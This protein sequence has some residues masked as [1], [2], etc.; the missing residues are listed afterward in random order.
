MIVHGKQLLH[1][2]HAPSFPLAIATKAQRKNLMMNRHLTLLLLFVFSIG[3]IQAQMARKIPM[4][5]HFTQASCGP[6]ATQN[7]IFEAVRTANIGNIN[8]VAVHTSWPGVDPMY[9]VNP[10]EA[11]AM[12]ALYGILGVPNMIMDGVNIGGPAGVTQATIDDAASDCSPVRVRVSETGTSTRNVTINIES[13]GPP[14]AGGHVVRAFVVEDPLVYGSPPGSNGETVFPNVFRETLTGT[15]GA[16]LALPAMGSSTDLTYSY[17]VDPSWNEPNVYVI[18]YVANNTTREVLNSG[19]SFAPDYEAT[20]CGEAF[21]IGAASNSFDAMVTTFGSAQNLTITLDASQPADWSAAYDFMGSTYSSSTTVSVGAGSMEDL[22]LNVTPGSTIGLGEYILSVESDDPAF[23]PQSMRFYINNGVTDLV[24]TNFEGFGDGSAPDAFDWSGIYSNGLSD[25][26]RDTRAATTHLTYLRGMEAAALGSVKNLYFNVGWTFPSAS[27]QKVQA[28]MD[29][30]DGGGNLFISGQDIGWEINDG[31]PT[32][33]NTMFYEDYLFADYISD[34][35]SSS[36][37]FEFD[38]SDMYFGDAGGADIDAVYGASFVFPEQ[39]DP[40]GPEASPLI[41]Y[42]G[43]PSL[44]GGLRIE[45]ANYKAVYLG[46]GIEMIDDPALQREVVKL[47]H[48]YFYGLAS[49]IEFEQALAD[50]FG[51]NQPNPASTST[52]VPLSS[53]GQGGMLI[54]NDATG[55]MVQRHTVAAGQ[56]QVRLDLSGLPAGLYSYHLELGARRSPAKKLTVLR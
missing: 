41:Y 53:A 35:S 6:C 44:N 3:S 27:D 17:T 28:L 23:A 51:Q 5:E 4:F 24:V 36:S 38:A 46:I 26:G 25:A 14:P 12:V 37:S 43:D 21:Q 54:L 52:I 31:A 40:M 32:A 19:S 50:A 16:A 55:R 48:D 47:A 15:G 39:I 11:D 20:A 45:T 29:F 34:G 22:T 30:M 56:E 18:A 9:N 1:A 10:T 49:G 8:H 42:N 2:Q 13:V 33:L 7:P